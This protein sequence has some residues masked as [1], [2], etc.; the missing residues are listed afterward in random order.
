MS[1]LVPLLALFPFE[2]PASH[3]ASAHGRLVRLPVWCFSPCSNQVKRAGFGQSV[4]KELDFLAFL[5]SVTFGP[6][7]LASAG[8]CRLEVMIAQAH[9][10]PAW[11][12]C[13]MR[14]DNRPVV[15]QYAAGRP[16]AGEFF[17]ICSSLRYTIDGPRATHVSLAGAEMA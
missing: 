8:V 9:L 17:D 14:C 13:W 11:H 5:T 3:F 7:A 12:A 4:S 16:V 15:T 6:E 2:V 1:S 10:R